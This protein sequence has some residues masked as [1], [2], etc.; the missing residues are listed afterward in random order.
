[1]NALDSVSE[2]NVVSSPQL[3]VLDNQTAQL[4]VGDEV[5]IVTQQAEGI[6][7]SDARIV[8]TTS[9]A[10]FSAGEYDLNNPHNRGS[11]DPWVAY[12]YS[13]RANLH[14]SLELDARLKAAGSQVTVYAADPGFSDT[15]LQSASVRNSD[16]A[17]RTE[18]FERIV[19]L[20]L[21]VGI[22][23]DDNVRPRVREFVNKQVP[24]VALTGLLNDVDRDC[25]LG[26][27]HLLDEPSE[28]PI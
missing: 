22:D 21:D 15:D 7:T 19:T 27:A 25:Q 16:G 14:F 26:T 12:G 3:L 10:R 5:P 6:E 8:N 28:R 13:K 23:Q 24:R 20:K 9:T 18:F 1:M 17:S 4:Q 2:V 11:Y